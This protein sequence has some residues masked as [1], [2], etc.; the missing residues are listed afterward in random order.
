MLPSKK[1]IRCMEIQSFPKWIEMFIKKSDDKCINIILF[2]IKIIENKKYLVGKGITA[3]GNILSVISRDGEIIT[4]LP[5]NKWSVAC[6]DK[7]MYSP[8]VFN[9]SLVKK[10]FRDK[11]DYE[12]PYNLLCSRIRSFKYKQRLLNTRKKQLSK[13]EMWVEISK[14]PKHF[15]EFCLDK[16]GYKAIFSLKNRHI[17]YCTHCQQKVDFL[18]ELVM[19]REYQCPF[20]SKLVVAIPYTKLSSY[21]KHKCY[22]M[23]DVFNERMCVRHYDVFEVISVT[24]GDKL[25]NIS[26]KRDIWEYERDLFNKN[27]DGFSY[28]IHKYDFHTECEYWDSKKLTQGYHLCGRLPD[29]YYEEE[30]IYTDNFSSLS[31]NWTEKVSLLKAINSTKF[32]CFRLEDLLVNEPETLLSEKLIKMGFKILPID[33]LNSVYYY[34]YSSNILKNKSGNISVKEFLGVNRS[35]IKLAIENDFDYSMLSAMQKYYCTFKD[36]L[37]DFILLYDYCLASS[38]SSKISTLIILAVD[39]CNNYKTTVRQMVSYLKKQKNGSIVELF[40]YVDMY[41]RAY[42]LN[43]NDNDCAIVKYSKSFLYPKDL[44]IA[45]NKASEWLAEELDKKKQLEIKQK[46][47]ILQDIV[48]S[49]SV[50]DNKQIGE[51]VFK[52]PHSNS[53]F[54]KQG[55]LMNICVGGGIYFERMCLGKSIICFVD[56]GSTPYATVEFKKG[57]LGLTLA[58]AQ[59]A[60]HKGVPHECEL[61]IL[62]FKELLQKECFAKV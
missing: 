48:K 15:Y 25:E 33:I 54:V 31:K 24:G 12:K 51:Y 58:Q 42:K 57:P 40:D 29:R 3:N 38:E 62:E 52:F 35:F 5:N 20:C 7:H 16:F 10:F 60:N 39:F 44:M 22:S 26:V 2:S 45:H 18:D 4:L 46:E 53:D 14:T 32:D 17:G 59:L 30:S 37:D 50:L 43:Q 19:R 55:A 8:I 1:S 9:G 41:L 28:Y 6:I 21:G 49:F 13:N 23:L 34:P 56:I 47:M 27:G 61:K 36:K 11:G